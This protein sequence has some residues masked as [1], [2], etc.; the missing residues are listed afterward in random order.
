MKIST[1]YYQRARNS[2]M[3]AAA[4][5]SAVCAGVVWSV[6]AGQESAAVGAALALV[7]LTG[8][9]PL[10]HM[11]RDARRMLRRAHGE[12]LYEWERSIRPRI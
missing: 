6:R 3:W 2:A 8:L 5:F 10:S 7:S 11:L 9:I 4:I 1:K 12:E